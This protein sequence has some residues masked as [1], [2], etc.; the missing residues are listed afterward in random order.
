[1]LMVTLQLSEK[2]ALKLNIPRHEKFSFVSICMV[3]FVSFKSKLVFLTTS[4]WR[5][6]AAGYMIFISPE[7]AV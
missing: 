4:P 3:L 6:A 2:R 5:H 7:H 1:M